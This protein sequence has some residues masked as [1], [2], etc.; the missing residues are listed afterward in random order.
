MKRI[1]I[2]INLVAFLA[3]LNTCLQAQTTI[4]SA[5]SGNWNVAATWSGGV[6]P[7]AGN[8]VTIAAGHTVTLVANT[9]ITTGSLTVTGTLALAGFDFTAGSLAGGGNIGSTSG[10]PTISVGSNNSNTTHSGALSGS[11]AL[12]KTGTGTLTLTNANTQTGITTIYGGAISINADNRLG[13]AP[14]SATPGN[15]VLDG[16]TL[17]TTNNFTLNANRGIT[18][19]GGGG[20][21]SAINTTT[22]QGVIDGTGA[23]TKAGAGTLILSGTNTYTGIT[24]LNAGTLSIAADNALGTAPLAATPGHLVLNGGTLATTATFTLDANRGISLDNSGGALSPGST[25]TLSYGGIIAGGGAFTKAGAGT[26]ILSG[27][28]TYT[29]NNTISGGTLSISADNNL[30]AAPISPTAGQL[31]FTGTTG[32]LNTSTTFTLD[33]NRGISFG[34]GVI[35]TIDTDNGT[36]L[37]YDGVMAGTGSLSKLGTGMLILSGT[38]TYTGATNISAGTLQLGTSSERISNSSALTVASGATFDMNGLS[39]TVGS[40]AGAGTV[41][42]GAPGSVTFTHAGNGST[43]F[44]G[45]IENGSGTVALTKAGTGILTL[46][47]TNTYTG[48]TTLNAGTLS[49]AADNALGTAPLAATPGHLVLNGGTLATTATFTLDANRGISLDN[50]GGALSPGSTF[51][52]SYGGIIAGSGA[53]T[54]AGAGTLILSGTNT[55]TGIT[56]ISGGTLSIDDDIRLGVPPVSAT[57]GRLM[58]DG[59]T[60]GTTAT[61]TLNANRGIGFSGGNIAINT[62]AGTTLTYGGVMAS[63][64]TGSTLVKTG[65]GRLTL[66]GANTNSGGT[67]ISEGT[68]Q[69]GASNV[70]PDRGLTVNGT[71]D[72]NGFNETVRSLSGSGLITT[73]VAGSV[74]FTPGVSGYSVSTTFSGIIED[75]SGT[76]NLTVNGGNGLNLTLTGDNTYTGITTLIG[77]NLLIDSDNR[78]GP[79][80]ATVVA[81]KLILDGGTLVTTATFTLH[82]NRGITMGNSAGTINTSPGTTLTYQGIISGG[83][84][85]FIK[86]GS[87]TLILSG[88]NTYTGATTIAN[89]GGTLRLGTSGA[90]PD[91]SALTVGSSATFDLAGFSKTIGSLAGTGTVTSSAAGTLTLTTGGN[92]TSTAFSGILQNGS[93]TSVAL[94]KNGSGTL[95]LGGANTYTGIT[96]ISGGEISINADTRLGAEPAIA[97]QGHLLLD[98]GTLATGTT[99]TLSANRGITLG[100]SGGTISI[101][102]GGGLR[103]LTYGGIIDGPGAL[104]KA[105]QLTGSGILILSG[106]NSYLGAT[107][108]SAGTLRLGAAG[109]IPD[110]SALTVGSNSNFDLAGFSETVGSLA[111]AGTVT[112]SAAGTPTFTAGDDNTSTTFSG[113]IQNGSATSVALT[114]NGTGTLTLTG[115][116][117]YTGETSISAGTLSIGAGSTTGA[118]S[119]S[120]NVTNNA[121]LIVNRS[122]TYSYAGVISGTGSLTKQGAGTFTISGANT[123]TGATTISVG[124]LQLS[125]ASERISNSSALTVAGGATFDLAGFSETVGSLAGAGTVSSSAAG[126]PTLTAGGDNTS[127]TFSGIMQNGSATSVDLTKN[128]TGTLT[129]TGANTYTGTTT[130]SAGTLSIGDGGTTGLVAGNIT[131]D[132]TLIFNRSNSLTFSGVISG[133]GAVTKQGNGT[134]TLTGANSYTGETSISAGTLRLGDNEVIPDASDV[135]L[136]GMLDM[137]GFNET[138]NGINFDGPSI[139]VVLNASNI[140]VNGAV[141][142]AG[143]GSYFQTNGTGSV[144]RTVTNGETFSFPVGNSAYNPLSITNNTGTAEWFSARVRDEVYEY[145]TFGEV[146]TQPRVKR[147][148]DIDKETPN[149]SAGGGVDFVF[150]WNSGE[151]SNPAPATYALFHHDANGNGWAEVVIGT[152]SQNGNSLSFSGYKGTFSPFGIGDPADPLPVELLYFNGTC[153]P[154]GLDFRWATAAEVNS[155]S[156]TLEH[157]A[158]LVEWHALHTQPSAGF[159]S[160]QK[161]YSTQLPH[162]PHLGPYFRLHQEDFDGKF[163]RFAPLHLEC[164]ET[165]GSGLLLYPN[166]AHDAVWVSGIAGTLDWEIFDTRG[167]RLRSGKLNMD[168]TPQQL[169]TQGLPAGMYLFQTPNARLPL[170]LKD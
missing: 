58:F 88:A 92:N 96:T 138:I 39:E 20:T 163:E 84:G 144:K 159:S 137:N 131:N 95:T 60:L 128:G 62:S 30:G 116:N 145:G 46:S 134:L 16:G 103:T 54:K 55:Y 149:A 150:N 81:N 139:L 162:Q 100:S 40:L 17:I 97:T 108:V 71:L 153:Q 148:W 86:E 26:L 141:T 45:L 73:S 14:G 167:R 29:G 169:P 27:T 102:T 146:L 129:L 125:T 63:S 9:D 34:A 42:S 158:N 132:A 13:T 101:L 83:T 72:L 99:F 130:I 136:T 107:T 127:T 68:I 49:I 94:T 104:T 161:D 48:I 142:G 41:T 98:G 74:T 168:E 75:G 80:P 160:S 151:V 51:T 133:I 113:T 77:G 33:A 69:L 85:S 35:G 5:T 126:T 70:I 6:V 93:A 112:S 15:V 109:V 120:S 122:N 11:L 67:T 38:N 65:T 135:V 8:N 123:Y 23:L 143:S 115:A 106:V 37:T 89:S 78:M 64:N 76:M 21:I 147:T 31:V 36:T 164:S 24:T 3:I 19:G 117:T 47:G 91:A 59:G 66:S 57:A 170:M 53:F 7:V 114:K 56:T 156:F 90:I 4:T 118:I 166:P 157:S 124:T 44:S 140:T 25:F 1:F 121:A 155:K 43:T 154:Q 50:S 12:T 105:G 82:E 110:A 111:G 2:T 152:G 165:S 79:P 22:Y 28:N 32:V 52:L 61:F 87:G 10:T 119:N 18:L